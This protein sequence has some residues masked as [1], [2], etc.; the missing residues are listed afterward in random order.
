MLG[1]WRRIRVP[2]PGK[3]RRHEKN[4]APTACHAN[5]L[6]F[7]RDITRDDWR[8]LE[9]SLKLNVEY[10]DDADDLFDAEEGKDG[11]SAEDVDLEAI[12]EHISRVNVDVIEDEHREPPIWIPDIA[13]PN[14]IFSLVNGAGKDGISS[15]VEF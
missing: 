8:K 5:C 7:I 12:N 2:L 3:E 13:L 9:I 14:L 15:M 10:D 4:G 1:I 6:R 11:K